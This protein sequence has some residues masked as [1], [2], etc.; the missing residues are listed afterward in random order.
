MHHKQRTHFQ[1]K[2]QSPTKIKNKKLQFENYEIVK[3]VN[4]KIINTKVEKAKIDIHGNFIYKVK[5]F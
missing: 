2:K 5:I 3:D 4:L 1:K